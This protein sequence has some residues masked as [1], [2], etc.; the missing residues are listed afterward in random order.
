MR[1]LKLDSD[2]PVYCKCFE[3]GSLWEVKFKRTKY[4]SRSCRDKW[5][6]KNNKKKV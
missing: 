4:C 2:I 1:K 3:C 6:Y 5:N